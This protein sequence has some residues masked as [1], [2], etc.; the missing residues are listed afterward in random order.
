MPA[1]QFDQRVVGEPMRFLVDQRL[2]DGEVRRVLAEESAEA[3]FAQLVAVEPMAADEQRDLARALRAVCDHPCCGASDLEV[4]D[5][6][7]ARTHAGGEVRQQGENRDAAPL[8]LLHRPGQRRMV[9]ADDGN[10]ARACRQPAQLLDDLVQR[11]RL[12]EVDHCRAAEAMRARNRGLQLGGEGP[13][14]RIVRPEQQEAQP[15]LRQVPVQAPADQVGGVKAD[16][17]RRL[18][19]APGRVLA[20]RQPAV[21]DAIDG[22][23]ADAG[24]ASKICNGRSLHHVRP[25]GQVERKNDR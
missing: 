12:G 8:Q 25:V 13:V 5:A 18:V 21:E 16:F 22:R 15:K 3:D 23:D 14:E 17:R 9:R 19:D 20:H 24:G 1:Q 7:I 6:D 11:K 4:V 10:G 2:H